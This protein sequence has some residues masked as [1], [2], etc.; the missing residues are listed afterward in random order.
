MGKLLIGG[1][2]VWPLACG[3]GPTS[4]PVPEAARAV[5]QHPVAAKPPAEPIDVIA[6]LADLR[7]DTVS[8]KT[9]P[10][11]L[12]LGGTTI[13]AHD[14]LVLEVDLLEERGREVRVGVRLD[15]ARFAVW[16]AR[17]RLLGVLAR[18]QYIRARPSGEH[19]RAGDPIEVTLRSGARVAKLAR[20][21][22][23]TQIRYIG[24]LEIEGWVPD[25]ALVERGAAGRVPGRRLA[26]GRK[27]LTVTPGA[28][29]RSEPRMNARVLALLHDSYFV[30]QVKPLDDGWTEVR[31]EDNDVAVHGF[32]SKRDPPGRLHRRRDAE[33]APATPTNATVAAWTCLHADGEPIGFTTVA[34]LV[35]LER[36]ARVGWFELTLDTPWG[37]LTFEA[38]GPVETALEPCGSPP[39]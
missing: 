12:I 28:Q 27:T 9:G 34:T 16:T 11:Q 3:A 30:D 15:Q 22:G 26:S 5:K 35:Q 32:L 21:N 10:A 31:Y 19:V 14:D 24:A 2:L 20:E 25:E 37:P 29:I 13:Q 1:A 36:A 38:R 23:Y 18:E 7:V 33:P 4:A 8:I 17:A 6:V 39:T